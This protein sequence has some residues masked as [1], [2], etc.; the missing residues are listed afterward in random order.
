MFINLYAKKQL[1]KQKSLKINSDLHLCFSK[2][3]WL[4]CDPQNPYVEILTPTTLECDL[5]WRQSLYRGNQ[6][7]LRSLGWVL[8]RFGD[9]V[10]IEVIK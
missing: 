3:L 4:N 2:L 8:I 9:R 5:T 7:R 10:F 1:S 6:V